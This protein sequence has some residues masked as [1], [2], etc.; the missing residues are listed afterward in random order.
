M[1]KALLS[2]LTLVLGLMLF[3]AC[4]FFNT[5]KQPLKFLVIDTLDKI[6]YN[7]LHIKGA[8]NIPYALESGDI[9]PALE[10]E[11]EFKK[12]VEG[13]TG[14]TLKKDT[15]LFFYCADE[16]CTSSKE[17]ADIASSWGYDA[18]E[19]DSGIKGWFGLSL[20]GDNKAWYPVEPAYT[21]GFNF[22]NQSYINAII[23]KAPEQNTLDKWRA[24]AQP[25]VD[26]MKV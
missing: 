19:Y 7:E 20:Y 17:A 10:S 5:Q 14:S 21:T 26:A 11:N 23:D 18:F 16:M 3:P 22:K 8:I 4:D 13:I 25:L 6:L 12:L 24:E 9:N 2:N 15:K 1:K